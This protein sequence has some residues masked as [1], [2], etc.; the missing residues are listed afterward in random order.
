MEILIDGG[1]ISRGIFGEIRDEKSLFPGSK[2]TRKSNFWEGKPFQCQN[3]GKF[4]PW[5]TQ[6]F[7]IEK[8]G[9]NKVDGS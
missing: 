3:G 2:P 9:V 8:D 6:G 4:R 1:F 7:S 5:L